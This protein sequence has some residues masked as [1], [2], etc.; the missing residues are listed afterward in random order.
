MLALKETHR[1]VR[2]RLCGFVRQS[3]VSRTT[4]HD[5]G[6]ALKETQTSTIGVAGIPLKRD[7]VTDV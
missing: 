5:R 2:A 7:D 3:G 4:P 6:V 1:V